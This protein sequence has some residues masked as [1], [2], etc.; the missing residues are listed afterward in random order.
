MM[1]LA[2][3]GHTFDDKPLADAG[4][5][6]WDTHGSAKTQ[7]AP[8]QGIRISQATD[9]TAVILRDNV[10]LNLQVPHHGTLHSCPPVDG[11]GAGTGTRRLSRACR[12][13]AA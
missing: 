2:C 13:R 11:Q 12:R 3:S 10:C 7:G 9:E 4:H 8:P 1:I 5:I 6:H